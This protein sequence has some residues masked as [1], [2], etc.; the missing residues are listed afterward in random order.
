MIG[1]TNFEAFLITSIILNVT[2]GND[3]IYILSKTLAQGKKAG[4]ISVLG[5]SSGILF[6][7]ILAVFGLSII[8][9]KSI[10]IFNIIKYAGA[11][12]IIYLGY[13]M[14]INKTALTT[15]TIQKSKD[16]NYW[17]IYQQG[18]LTNVLNPKVAL[19]FISVLPQ[20]IKPELINSSAPFL[21]LGVTFIATATLWTLVL[22]I[23]ASRIF[24]RLKENSKI[25][26]CINKICGATLIGL[27][28]R[29]ALTPRK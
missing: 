19:F 26:G 9:A 5:I 25:A 18:I 27:G 24:Y 28:I 29:V 14:F 22:T 20:F 16:K 11:L 3:T 12:Y 13:Q 2:P 10:F 17:K 15:G 7:T 4:I 8:I 6:H 23:F 1:I 21:I